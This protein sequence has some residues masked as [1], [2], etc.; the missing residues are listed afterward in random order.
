MRLL[1]KDNNLDQYI[2]KLEND[3]KLSQKID[4]DVQRFRMT[5]H[6]MAFFKKNVG[7]TMRKN[8]QGKYEAM[9]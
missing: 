6:L 3:P 4:T 2:R 9:V 7:V 8:E 5:N 1:A